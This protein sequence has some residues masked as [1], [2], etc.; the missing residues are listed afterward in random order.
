MN[1]IK[2]INNTTAVLLT[3]NI[4]IVLFFATAALVAGTTY[5]LTFSLGPVMLFL[6]IPLLSLY[7]VYII[8]VYSMYFLINR[9]Y[10]CISNLNHILVISLVISYCVLYISFQVVS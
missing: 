5:N 4:T 2:W 8:S 6:T 3:I 9:D 1:Y 7:L 10:R